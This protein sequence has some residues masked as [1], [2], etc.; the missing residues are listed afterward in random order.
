MTLRE[1]VAALKARGLTW[2]QCA[3]EAGCTYDQAR[4]SQRR[5]KD[6]EAPVAQAAAPEPYAGAAKVAEPNTVMGK[7]GRRTSHFGAR[8]PGRYHAAHMTDLHHGSKHNDSAAMLDFMAIAKS[9]G[10]CAV[11][12]SGDIIDG[13]DPKLQRDQRCIETD[14]Q[15]AEAI[16]VFAAG[17]IGVPHV[18]I[19]GNHDGYSDK[20]GGICS[21]R[22]LE[23]RMRERGVNWT[24]LDSCLGRVVLHGAKIEL[25]H[26][27]GG[28][29]TRN[30]VRR[31]LN[32]RAEG[33]ER[34][35]EPQVLLVGHYHRY[36]QFEAFP[37]RI[38][39]VSGA[40]FQ[41]KKS[42]F[43][44]RIAHPW[45]LGGGILSWTVDERG[46]AG[47]F[48]YEYFPVKRSDAL[49]WAA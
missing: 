16:D 6:A 35:D 23:E 12:I 30:A 1:K 10:V 47:E 20:A 28:S 2:A 4:D 22:L 5:A 26:G 18:A 19:S 29:G 27:A 37:E 42:E 49:G 3:A 41:R 34:G 43:A 9:R 11:L 24:Y 31:V 39:C 48:S 46:V 44:N 17:N 14:D 21:G 36:A 8:E 13:F 40:T 15:L 25:W 33:Y 32:H 38:F 45:D 7:I